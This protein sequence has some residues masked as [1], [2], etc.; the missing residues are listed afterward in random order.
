MQETTSALPQPVS[1]SVSQE[2]SASSLRAATPAEPPTPPENLS[3]NV[4][5]YQE[6]KGERQAPL[7]LPRYSLTVR[8]CLTKPQAAAP[9]EAACLPAEL[10]E[11][12]S[13][14]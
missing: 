12:L 5:S 13:E 2:Q 1:R 11:Q 8:A 9:G 4:P 3:S 14:L 7:P 10:P 6:Q